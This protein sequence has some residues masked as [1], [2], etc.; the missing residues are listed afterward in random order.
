MLC[1]YNVFIATHSE[2]I[3]KYIW[4]SSKTIFHHKRF[5]IADQHTV[6]FIQLNACAC[7]CTCTCAHTLQC[8]ASAVDVKRVLFIVCKCSGS[9]FVCSSFTKYNFSEEK[10]IVEATREA[11]Q[12]MNERRFGV[13][14]TSLFAKKPGERGRRIH[15]YWACNQGK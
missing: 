13:K 12:K 11:N 9:L 14:T 3:Y 8:I 4:A 10:N 1:V 15:V 5:S 6:L 2:M 7:T